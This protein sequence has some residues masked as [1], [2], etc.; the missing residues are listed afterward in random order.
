MSEIEFNLLDLKHVQKRE[1]DLHNSTVSPSISIEST[2]NDTD[3]AV[4]DPTYRRTSNA[5][6]KPILPLPTNFRKP[7]PLTF[8]RRNLGENGT[9]IWTTSTTIGPPLIPIPVKPLTVDANAV[10][11]E[12]CTS[13]IDLNNDLEKMFDTSKASFDKYVEENHIEFNKSVCIHIFF[14]LIFLPFNNFAFIL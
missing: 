10:M 4:L 12:N 5:M 7:M 6:N 14:Y 2:L 13:D 11:Q 8:Y 9:G 1:T 3:M